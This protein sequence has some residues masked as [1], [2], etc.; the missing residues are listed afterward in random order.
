MNANETAPRLCALLGCVLL[1]AKCVLAQEPS[2]IQTGQGGHSRPPAL[3]VFLDDDFQEQTPTNL[4]PIKSGFQRRDG[5]LHVLPGGGFSVGIDSGP[6]VELEIEQDWPIENLE[7]SVTWIIYPTSVTDFM[8]FSALAAGS[9]IGVQIERKRNDEG[10]LA[11]GVRVFEADDGGNQVRLIASK[12]VPDGEESLG[13]LKVIYNYGL[14]QVLQQ[15]QVLTQAKVHIDYNDIRKVTLSV[16]GGVGIELRS[17]SVRRTAATPSFT[18]RQKLQLLNAGKDDLVCQQ[19]LAEGKFKEAAEVMEG[20]YAVCYSVL[21]EWSPYTQ[22]SRL[23]LR[24]AHRNAGNYSRA[25]ALADQSLQSTRLLMGEQHPDYAVSLSGVADLCASMGDYARAETLYAQ[26]RD[27]LQNVY[28]EEHSRFGEILNN[29]ASVYVRMGEYERAEQLYRQDRD[30]AG[31][32][33][34]RE[35]RYFAASLSSLANVCRLRGEYARAEALYA[36]A[37][38]IYA[39]ALGE[40]HPEYASN[41]YNLA[42]VYSLIGETDQAESLFT[43]ARD[44]YRDL[45]G[46]EHL[47]YASSLNELSRLYSLMGDPVRAEQL[48]MQAHQVLVQV[49]AKTLPSLSEAESRSWIARNGP[50]TD[51]VL[52]ALRANQK[53]EFAD[54]LR[55]G[56]DDQ[57]DG[58]PSAGWTISADRCLTRRSSRVFRVAGRT[59][60]TGPTRFGDSKS[61]T[62]CGVSPKRSASQR[63]E[64]GVGKATLRV[65]CGDGARGRGA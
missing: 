61:E 41:L 14:L 40:N 32:T 8:S 1:L 20:V 26:A 30:I 9:P 37:R 6:K 35:H 28:G 29:L 48:G 34:G 7:A 47:D 46:E 42:G 36:Q 49:A 51:I 22:S 64:G 3:E 45:L 54:S 53:M 11:T 10:E 15:D 33:L 23:R 55:D 63:T 58:S 65:E 43:R 56:L 17:V 59:L 60:K 39:T 52:A 2:E 19:L 13:N 31:R 5:V 12:N 50:R 38:D 16:G 25:V 44:T 27:I 24:R 57:G 62:I 4:K 18:W 21:G